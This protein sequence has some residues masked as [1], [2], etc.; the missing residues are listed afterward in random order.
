MAARIVVVDVSPSPTK[1]ATVKGDN[2]LY[3]RAGANNK[4]VSLDQWETV[5]S[6]RDCGGMFQLGGG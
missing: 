5:L 2:L 6:R 3:V 4:Q 1:P